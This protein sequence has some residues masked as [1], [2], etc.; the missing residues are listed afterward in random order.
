MIEITVK[1]INNAVKETILLP[2]K[3]FNCDA[4]ESVV[5][6]AVRSYL[7]NQRQGTHVTKTR[8]MVSGGG[9]KPW[10]QKHT[11]RARHGSIRSPLW[12]GGG[13]IFGPQP[14][15]YYIQL[16]KK[17]RRIALYKALTMKLADNEIV[18]VDVLKFEKPKTKEMVEV[19]RRLGLEG[20]TVLI[21]TDEKDDN[22]ILSARNIPTIE[23]ILVSDLNAY[24]VAANDVLLFTKE[25]IL[26]LGD[27]LPSEKEVAK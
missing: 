18:I 4:S 8:G 26:K 3:I 21:V 13:I 25:A 15:D 6:T 23:T 11:G 1:D 20:K 7:A 27:S 5:H 12:R 16:P 19:I 9:R 14:R 17:Q 10:K 2:E 22:L 24:H